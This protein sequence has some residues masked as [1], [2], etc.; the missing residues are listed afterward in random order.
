VIYPFAL[1]PLGFFMGILWEGIFFPLWVIGCLLSPFS[2]FLFGSRKGCLLEGEWK[3]LYCW[4]YF[5]YCLMFFVIIVGWLELF[6]YF[7]IWLWVW[8]LEPWTLSRLWTYCLQ[9]KLIY[10]SFCSFTC[11]LLVVWSILTFL[12][13][14]L[15]YFGMICK[16]THEFTC[17]EFKWY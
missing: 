3:W 4:L 11:E 14:I 1:S 16:R 17:F 5:P 9:K 10:L 13:E 12:F 7:V 8:A 15:L 6:I 2:F